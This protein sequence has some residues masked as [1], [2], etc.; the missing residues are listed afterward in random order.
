MQRQQEDLFI[1]WY[2][3]SGEVLTLN[4]FFLR[5]KRDAEVTG[6]FVS[7]L[8]LSKLKLGLELK[9]KI[10]S[11]PLFLNNSNPT[12]LS[13]CFNSQF[14][15][16]ETSCSSVVSAHSSCFNSQFW[17]WRPVVVRLYVCCILVLTHNF[18]MRKTVV[19]RLL[20]FT[21][22]GMWLQ[23]RQWQNCKSKQASVCLW[24]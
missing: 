8:Q 17:G 4:R 19:V 21:V 12:H 10:T 23:S 6:R 3:Q 5:L 11:K 20:V 16:W 15:G 22:C 24:L 7:F 2:F 13:S 18:E 1:F 14:W 9:Q